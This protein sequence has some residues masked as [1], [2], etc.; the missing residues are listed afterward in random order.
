MAIR[1]MARVD[2]YASLDVCVYGLLSLVFCREL[3]K[4]AGGLQRFVLEFAVGFSRRLLWLGPCRHFR[5]HSVIPATPISARQYFHQRADLHSV[6]HHRARLNHTGFYNFVT[7]NQY[8]TALAAQSLASGDPVQI[9]AVAALTA[10]DKTPCGSDDVSVTSA[11]ANA[12]G[13]AGEVKGGIAG[14]TG[15]GGIACSDPGTAGCYNGVITMTN[16]PGT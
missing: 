8:A 9:A 3:Q 4:Q 16:E 1:N 5:A 10:N 13:I 6:R 11:L 7:Y 12:L 15:P 14:I 2:T